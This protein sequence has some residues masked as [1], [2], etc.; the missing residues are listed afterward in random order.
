MTG[1]LSQN[2]EHVSQIYSKEWADKFG[3]DGTKQRCMRVATLRD[4]TPIP[5]LNVGRDPDVERS[6]FGE[7][8]RV[9]GD[10]CG[11]DGR[12]WKARG[13]T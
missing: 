8:F 3:R 12:H 10:K 9:A 6:A 2:C 7:P 4:G 13:P 5:N 11:P 1:P